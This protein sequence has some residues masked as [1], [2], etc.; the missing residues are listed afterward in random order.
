MRA[1]MRYMRHVVYCVPT[2][3]NGK[4]QSGP[5]ELSETSI[6]VPVATST[7]Y[8]IDCGIRSQFHAGQNLILL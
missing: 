1:A 7:A 6:A 5:I 4:W 2:A 3:A 8:S